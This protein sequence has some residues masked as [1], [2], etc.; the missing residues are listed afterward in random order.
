MGWKRYQEFGAIGFFRPPGRGPNTA[1]QRGYTLVELVLVIL[2]VSALT[3]V[4]MPT[5]APG[6]NIKLDLVATEIADAMRFARVESLRLGVARGFR[7]E[8][9]AKRVR[10]FSMD[11]QTTPAT[12]VYDIYHPIDKQFYDRSFAQQP[13]A[14]TGDMN[15]TPTYRGTCDTPENIFFDTNGI[16]WCADPD[17]V[18]LER[19]D[20]TLTLGVASRVVTL[21]G[22]TGRVTIQ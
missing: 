10:V 5:L 1:G 15:H 20:V 3:V 12:L 2:I 22:L 4:I 16:P 19:F 13:Y 7:Q 8:S 14:F 11:T 9:T 21:H 18:L 17:N 6:E